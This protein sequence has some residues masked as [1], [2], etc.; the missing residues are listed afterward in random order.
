[1]GNSA[2]AGSGDGVLL[3]VSSD[4]SAHVFRAGVDPTATVAMTV[5]AGAKISGAGLILDSTNATSLSSSAVLDGQ[6]I[7]LDSGQISILLANPGT[8]QPTSGLVIAG[9]VLQDLEAAQNVSLLSYSSI[10]IYGTGQF[11][12]PTLASLALHAAEIRGFNNGGGVDSFAA[13]TISLDNSPGQV[14]L[15]SIAPLDGTLNFNS[16]TFSLGANQ[17]KLDQYANVGINAPGGMLVHGNG[18]LSTQGAL[19]ITAGAVAASKGAD[20]TD[21]RGRRSREIQA[22]A[23]TS[24]SALASGAWCQPHLRRR[25]HHRDK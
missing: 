19:S 11:G 7:T 20:Q 8:L 25:Q 13:H 24:R 10:D 3:R 9:Q 6:S 1:M 5:G 12:A 15:G 16:T 22:P 2:V 23:G 21:H 17:V 18:G 4:S 14:A